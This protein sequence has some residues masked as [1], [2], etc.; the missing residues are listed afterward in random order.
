MFEGS[1]KK[2]RLPL[3]GSEEREAILA[4]LHPIFRQVD[5]GFHTY[6]EILTDNPEWKDG[7]IEQE[8]V[9]RGVE[10]GFAAECVTFGPMAWGRAVAEQLGVTCSPLF[11]LHSLID[12]SRREMPLANEL[13]YAWARQMIGFY[14]TPE[15][16]E[17]F[18]LVSTRSAELGAISKALHAGTSIE[19]LRQSR[20]QPSIVYLR[21]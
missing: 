5:A 6:L 8:M 7:R 20:L 16:N 1:P 18:K 11:R 19:D 21:R 17:V 4:G 9:R 3:A 12:D 10:T 15:R 13:A 2:R 14:R